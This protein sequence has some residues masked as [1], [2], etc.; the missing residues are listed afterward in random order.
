MTKHTIAMAAEASVAKP[1]DIVLAVARLQSLMSVCAMALNESQD[2]GEDYRVRC[3]DEIR[4]V[5]E[6][7]AELTGDI[8]VKVERAVSGKGGTA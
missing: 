4:A 8:V 2:L 7:G 1:V 5:L 3:Q 6:F